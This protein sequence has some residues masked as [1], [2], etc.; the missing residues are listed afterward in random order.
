M[1]LFGGPGKLPNPLVPVVFPTLW[2]P[3]KRSFSDLFL[4]PDLA[5]IWARLRRTAKT[6]YARPAA[7]ISKKNP[8]MAHPAGGAGPWPMTGL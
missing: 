5:Q 2:P 7:E 6:L 1:G 4:D 3:Q 8:V